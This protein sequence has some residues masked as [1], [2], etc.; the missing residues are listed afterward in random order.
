[1]RIRG[2]GW[3]QTLSATGSNTA[4]T[5][6][7]PGAGDLHG[8]AV[9]LP[10]TVGAQTICV[11]ALNYG[12]GADTT[13]G[14][15]TVTVPTALTTTRIQGTDRYNTAVQVSQQ[16][17]PGVPVVYVAS[18]DNYPD[19]LSVAPVAAK[20]GVPLLLVTRDSIPPSVLT[21][22][23]RL[24]PAKIVAVGGTAAVSDAVLQQ[25]NNYAPATRL[26]GTDRY[27]TSLAVGAVLGANRSGKVYLATGANF[28]DALSAAAAAGYQDAPLILV[29]GSTGTVSPA[30]SAALTSWGVTQVTIVGGTSVMTDQF[31]A[32]VDAISGVTVTRVSGVDRYSTSA[33]VNSAAF[34]TPTGAF[35]AVGTAFPDALS[36]GALAG[37][38]G[39]PMY[40][41]PG[42]CVPGGTVT[43]LAASGAINVTLLGGTSALT[44]GAASFT[45]CS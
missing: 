11:D 22:L 8:F 25:L 35:M 5:S 31:A 16:T 24:H 7:F 14:C 12:L 26:Q 9:T 30:L 28:P 37:K 41:V 32:A 19:A 36:G 27:N 23:T 13:I 1:V 2:A 10:A 39:K 4:A 45:P 6:A 40:L 33:A 38:Q 34:P 43:K 20:Q 3:S 21:E 17:A 18:G 29:N 44:Q 15:S 42:T